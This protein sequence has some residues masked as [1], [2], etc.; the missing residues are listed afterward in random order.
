MQPLPLPSDPESKAQ[1]RPA[2]HQT[3]A[4]AQSPTL[5]S[6]EIVP[7]PDG[8]LRA[9]LMCICTHLVTANVWGLTISFGIF[10]AY[11]AD[12]LGVPPSQISWIGAM[13]IVLGN[14]LAVFS[15]RLSDAGHFRLI[16]ALGSSLCTLGLVTASFSTQYWQLMLTQGLL[17]GIGGG[18]V[19]CPSFSVLAT[20]FSSKRALAL[21]IASCGNITGGLM[22]PA[23]ARQL[24]PALGF[25]WTMRILALIQLVLFLFANVF[26]RSRIQTQMSG[27]FVDLSILRKM[28]FTLFSF[29]V[30]TAQAGLYVVLFYLPQFGRTQLRPPLS[31]PDSLNLL[32]VFSGANLLGRLLP[33]RFADRAGPVNLMAPAQVAGGVMA[34]CWTRVSTPAGLHAW[35][36]LLGLAVGGVTCLHASACMSLARDLRTAGSAMGLSMAINSLNTVVG[37]PVAGAVVSAMGGRYEGAQA[38]AGCLMLLGAA[39]VVGA[40]AVRRHRSGEKWDEKV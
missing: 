26:M 23:V 20:Y 27:P 13:P 2:T 39:L 6:Q 7:P 31:Y 8:G 28:D 3:S 10:Q 16:M 5:A 12:S 37:P 21:G 22:Y 11:Y 15:G 14:L 17:F 30:M 1:P 32:L 19:A 4:L 38:Y 18:L 40:K 29:G 25:G 9:W 33:T 34:L 36:A 24:L 35:T